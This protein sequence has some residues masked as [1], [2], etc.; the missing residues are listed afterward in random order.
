MT[1]RLTINPEPLKLVGRR[2]L[3]S[4]RELRESVR[5][6]A[7]KSNGERCTRIQTQGSDRCWQHAAVAS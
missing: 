1:R 2:T 3:A 4:E 6:T 5:C 7:I